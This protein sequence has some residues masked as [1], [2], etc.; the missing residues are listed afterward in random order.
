MRDHRALVQR[1]RLERE[2]GLANSQ[3]LASLQV[4]IDAFEERRTAL[5]IER[6]KSNWR[7]LADQDDDARR[8]QELADKEYEAWQ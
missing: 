3:A 8:E 5:E 7:C 6:R 4:Q 1:Q 2:F